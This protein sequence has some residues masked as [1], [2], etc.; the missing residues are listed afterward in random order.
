MHIICCIV[1][2]KKNVSAATASAVLCHGGRR[3]GRFVCNLRVD[4]SQYAVF[5]IMKIIIVAH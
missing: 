3:M 1:K 4:P 5:K 2:I